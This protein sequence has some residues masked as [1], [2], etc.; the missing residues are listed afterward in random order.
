MLSKH[1]KPIIVVSCKPSCKVPYVLIE[2]KFY[3][4]NSKTLYRIFEHGVEPAS[5]N[6]KFYKAADKAPKTGES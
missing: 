4:V 2:F 6:Y 3:K 1:C 5:W